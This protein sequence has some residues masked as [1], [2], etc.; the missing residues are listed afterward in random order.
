MSQKLDQ[1]G[2]YRGV[3]IETGLQLSRA[4]QLPMFVVT[5]RAD[6]RYIEDAAELE[7]FVDAG[8]IEDATPQWV[9]WSQYDQTIRNYMVLFKTA[10][11]NGNFTEE[12]ASSN[13]GQI[14]T[15]FK[16]EGSS[17][18][19]LQN[20]SFDDH[21][22]LVRVKE[23]KDDQYGPVDVAW[24]DAFDAPPQRE[25]KS[26]D[27]SVVADLNKRLKVTKK[28]AAPKAAAAPKP[29]ASPKT[30]AT[31]A[32]KRKPKATPSPSP[33]GSKE[34]TTSSAATAPPAPA[35]VEVSEGETC[36]KDEAWNTVCVTASDQKVDPDKISDTWITVVGT[37]ETENGVGENDFTEHAWANVRDAVLEALNV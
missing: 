12:N 17:F 30:K 16:W 35:P 22:I 18:E 33:S 20:G 11:E 8:V 21:P 13:Y 31:V 4:S 19:E 28:K 6:E 14:Q 9:D 3:A 26:V 36:T 23:A 29:A 32:V 25:L 10:D 34:N 27:A 7:A 15:A 5:F 2:V 1:P 37:A 24:V